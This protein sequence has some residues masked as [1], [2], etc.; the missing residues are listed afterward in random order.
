VKKKGFTLIELLVVIAIIAILAA[1]LFP[2]FVTAK[3]RG[4][5]ASCLSN[6][7]QIGTALMT[8]ASDWNNWIPKA[9]WNDWVL[10]QSSQMCP[11]SGYEMLLMRY[12]KNW[13][14]F[15]CPLQDQVWVDYGDGKGAHWEK[16]R[17]LDNPKQKGFVSY[18]YNEAIVYPTESYLL[19]DDPNNPG[20]KTSIDRRSLT[21]FLAPSRTI[22]LAENY[23]GWHDTWD[24]VGHS[25]YQFANLDKERHLGSS[26]FVFCD[27]HAST[28]RWEATRSPKDLWTINPND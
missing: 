3:A 5:A 11:Y 15:F 27:G 2:V 23:W 7:R 25:I 21:D 22:L 28:M 9:S 6:T 8:Y 4:K 13:K 17:P 10:P 26:N 20:R 16:F 24:Q 19:K 12:V 18:G 1:I 14:V